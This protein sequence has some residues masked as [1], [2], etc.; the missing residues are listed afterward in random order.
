MFYEKD[1]KQ[2]KSP[3]DEKVEPEHA[4]VITYR[5]TTYNDWVSRCI[6]IADGYAQRFHIL[7][8]HHK[9]DC[10]LKAFSVTWKSY[11]PS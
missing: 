3:D 11:A 6:I 2:H 4:Y 7:H 10:R 8:D 9:D 5:D 1:E